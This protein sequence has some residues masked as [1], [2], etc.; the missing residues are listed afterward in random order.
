M[1]EL[2]DNSELIVIEGAGHLSNLENPEQFNEH[3]KSF[4]SKN[5]K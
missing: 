1:N 5:F 4:L 3:L 2:I